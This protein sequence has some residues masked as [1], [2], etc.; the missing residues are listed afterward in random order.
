MHKSLKCKV[1]YKY[2]PQVIYL[3]LFSRK[4]WACRASD[5]FVRRKKLKRINLGLPLREKPSI[6]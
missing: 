4:S 3:K 1:K 5:T 2:N 6:K